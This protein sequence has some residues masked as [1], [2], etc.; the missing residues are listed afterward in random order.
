LTPNPVWW[1]TSPSTT[2]EARTGSY[3]L[4]DPLA[5]ADGS[6]VADARAW[7]EKRRPELLK[8]IE[9]NEYGR[10]PPRPLAMTFDVFD[11]GTPAFNGRALRKQVTIYFTA[12][13][14]EHYVDVLYYLPT[15]TTG[16]VPVL[17]NSAGRQ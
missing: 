14:T 10:V 5:F 15:T 8:L 12:N 13:R 4:P 16:P 17:L 11:R 6:P 7:R 9:D 3:T 1:R 2:T